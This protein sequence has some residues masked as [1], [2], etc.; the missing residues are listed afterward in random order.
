M[1]PQNGRDLG[2]RI[3][4]SHPAKGEM[5]VRDAGRKGG[6]KGGGIRKQQLGAKGYSELG[7]K[8]GQ[9]VRELVEQ[10]RR[11]EGQVS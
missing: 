5:S 4:G 3:D 2:W 8:G 11:A 6:H 9:R 10:G 1:A 7:R